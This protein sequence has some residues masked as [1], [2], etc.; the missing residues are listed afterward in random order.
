M[1]ETIARQSGLYARWLRWMYRTG[2][3]NRLAAVMNRIS[4]AI[5]SAG[6]WPSRLV[7]LEVPGRRTGRRISF[8]LVVAQHEGERYLVSMLG[9]RAGW[10]ANVRANAG[11][12]V[13]SNGRVEHVRLTEVDPADRAPIL[14]RY[15]QVAPGA[16]PHIPVDRRAPLTEFERIA[17][18]YPVFRVHTDLT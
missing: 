8:P 7:T 10:V 18:R 15:L 6:V 12:A 2:R 14:R 11:R 3:P 13:L 16:R 17:G 5:A 9:A 1:S 4:A